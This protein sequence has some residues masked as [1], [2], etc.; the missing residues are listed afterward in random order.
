MWRVLVGVIIGAV[1]TGGAWLGWYEGQQRQKPVPVRVHLA[2]DSA[3]DIR[4]ESCSVNPARTEALVYGTFVVSK[5]GWPGPQWLF[6][7]SYGKVIAS[8]STS[9]G[10]NLG[11]ASQVY[12]EGQNNWTV[13]VNLASGFGSP[14]YCLVGLYGAPGPGAPAPTTTTSSTTTSAPAKSA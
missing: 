4:A 14:A 6:V 12:A 11:Q 8:I 3:R 10:T 2:A 7:Y 5:Q 13:K 1:L 9:T